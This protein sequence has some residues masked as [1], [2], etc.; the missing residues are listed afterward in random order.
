MLK[1]IKAKVTMRA[2]MYTFLNIKEKN[3]KQQKRHFI[4][5]VTIT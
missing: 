1:D 5:T 2:R 3:V 4:Q